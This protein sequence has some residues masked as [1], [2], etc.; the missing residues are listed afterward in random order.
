MYQKHPTLKMLFVASDHCNPLSIKIPGMKWL[1][2]YMSN[3]EVSSP[4]QL[5]HRKDKTKLCIQPTSH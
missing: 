5:E 4:Q 1:V 3:P 2:G